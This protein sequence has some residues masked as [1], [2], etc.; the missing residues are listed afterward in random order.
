MKRATLALAATIS[1]LSAVPA[2]A[3]GIGH[4]FFMRGTIVDTGANGTVVC[5]GREDGAQ[6]GQT[7]EVYRA[8]PIPGSSYKGTGPVF[9]R[10]LVGHVTIDAIVDEHFARVSVKDGAPAKH[11]IV[12]LRRD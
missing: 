12:E 11:D 2:L 3:Q 4:T 1:L 5:I 9:R 7:L 6:V 10:N 8:V